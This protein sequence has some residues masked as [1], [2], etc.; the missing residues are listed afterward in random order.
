MVHQSLGAAICAIM[1]EVRG[2][3]KTGFNAAQKYAYASDADLLV[4]LQPKCAEHGIF[5]YPS[6]QKVTTEE[7]G[8][9][10]SGSRRWLTSSPGG[11]LTR[12]HPT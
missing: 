11:R 12:G 9:T 1:S 2:V 10:K 7:V 3:E 6:Q 4:A 5:I 8:T